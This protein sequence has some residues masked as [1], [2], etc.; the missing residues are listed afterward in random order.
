MKERNIKNKEYGKKIKGKVIAQKNVGQT[1]GK[2]QTQISW[3][4]ENVKNVKIKV[5]ELA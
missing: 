3:D 4:L 1:I 2:K 5:T